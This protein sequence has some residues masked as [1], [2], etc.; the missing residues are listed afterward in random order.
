MSLS[1]TGEHLQDMYTGKP[2]HSLVD[3]KH[4]YGETNSK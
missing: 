2:L 4:V 3:G 1:W